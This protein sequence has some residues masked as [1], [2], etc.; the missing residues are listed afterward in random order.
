MSEDL[1]NPQSASAPVGATYTFQSPP[2]LTQTISAAET[3]ATEGAN[4]H[5]ARNF[6]GSRAMLSGAIAGAIG[7]IVLIGREVKQRSL[8][9]A[10]ASAAGAMVGLGI[11]ALPWRKKPEPQEHALGTNPVP[12][13]PLPNPTPDPHPAHPHATVVSS[14]YEGRMASDAPSQSV[15]H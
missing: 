15:A 8:K 13:P 1:Q 9:I 6:A 7:G 10:A 11:S 4:A 12:M 5:R 2:Q 14:A 3:M